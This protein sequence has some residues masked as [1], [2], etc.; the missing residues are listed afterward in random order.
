MSVDEIQQILGGF[1]SLYADLESEESFPLKR[2]LLAHYTSIEAFECIAKNNE[3]WFSNPLYM[4]DLEELRFGIF[5]GSQLFSSSDVINAACGSDAR[6]KILHDAFQHYLEKFSNEHALDIYVF[7]LS[8]HNENN[9]DGLLSMWRGYGGNGKG[10]S[11]VFDTKQLNAVPASALVLAQVAYASAA[12]RRRWLDSKIMEFA[13]LL[14]KNT[15]PDDKLYLAAWTMFER[16]KL[17]AIF[18]KHHGFSE[19]RE[20]R[21]VYLKERDQSNIL[22]PMLGYVIGLQGVEPRLK[23]KVAPVDGHTADDLSLSKIIY[24]IILGPST[25]SPLAKM[26]FLRMLDSVGKPELKERVLASSIPFRAT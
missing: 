21:A 8:E 4:N 3:L 5:E 16:I 24:K 25:S 2:P 1:K 13:K 23:F 9:T 22:T 10:V 20:W 18:T 19:E 11:I 14:T 12:D 15:I 17:F 6:A 7:C 26:A